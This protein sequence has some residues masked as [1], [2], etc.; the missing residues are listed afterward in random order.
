M[1]R[2]QLVAP[3][4]CGRTRH[5]HVRRGHLARKTGSLGH[6]D[7]TLEF[8]E[9][10]PVT[11]EELDPTERGERRDDRARAAD[12]IRQP[13]RPQRPLSSLAGCL[14]G[15]LELCDLAIR[16]HQ[17][18]S[19]SQPLK[20]LNRVD[21]H[22]LGVGYRAGLPDQVRQPAE[23][24]SLPELVAQLLIAGECLLLL[25][26]GRLEVSHEIALRGALLAQLRLH[27]ER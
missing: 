21:R 13:P 7:R 14:G 16:G 11:D 8:R 24:P 19:R 22:R 12:L 9:T 25:G 15:E 27:R 5:H 3:V 17:L 2:G 4:P 23:R 20:L 6:F 1:P 26:R 18:P 10:R